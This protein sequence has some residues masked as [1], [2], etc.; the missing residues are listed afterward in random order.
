MA[1]YYKGDGTTLTIPADLS[2]GT[3]QIAENAVTYNKLSEAV[4]NTLDDVDSTLSAR[5]D[6]LEAEVDDGLHGGTPTPVTQASAMT[7]TNTIYLYVGSESG[8][9]YGYIYVYVNGAWTRTSLY[10]SA[11]NITVSGERLVIQ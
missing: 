8:Y 3:A 5:I 6:A 4:Q 7:D 11:S 10:G 2:V 1:T 9:D